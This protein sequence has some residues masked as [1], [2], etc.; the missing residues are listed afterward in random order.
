MKLTNININ[1]SHYSSDLFNYFFRDFPDYQ[2]ETF[3]I[4]VRDEEEAY[5]LEAELPG[6]KQEDVSIQVN[7]KKLTIETSIAEEEK[8]VKYLIHERTIKN[9]KRVFTLPKNAEKEKI[10]AK[11][12]NGV[13]ILTIPKTKESKPKKIKIN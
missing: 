11:M 2:C 5:L 12:E 6:F 7:D 1:D 3:K 9:Y 10:E 13:L 8:S 4:N